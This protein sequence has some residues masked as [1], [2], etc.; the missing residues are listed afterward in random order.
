MADEE[1]EEAAERSESAEF[2][3]WGTREEGV[4]EAEDGG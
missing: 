2:G 4:D 3:L 1:A